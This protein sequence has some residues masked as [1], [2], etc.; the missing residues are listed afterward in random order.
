MLVSCTTLPFTLEYSGSFKGSSVY[1]FT[2]KATTQKIETLIKPHGNPE[3]KVHRHVGA[4]SVWS[5]QGVIGPDGSIMETGQVTFGIH[6][7]HED[8]SF[9]YTARGSQDFDTASAA[10]AATITGGSGTLQGAKG[11]VTCAI[12]YNPDNTFHG[13]LSGYIIV[14]N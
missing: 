12:Y 8:N 13:W 1:N 4:L 5:G 10:V 6:N 9:T 7:N 2:A 3:S 14:P 11:K